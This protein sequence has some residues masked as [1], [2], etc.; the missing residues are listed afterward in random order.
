MPLAT[1][2]H[3]EFSRARPASQTPARGELIGC[4]EL[5]V[6]FSSSERAGNDTHTAAPAIAFAAAGEFEALCGQAGDERSA[7]WHIHFC[8]EGLEVNAHVRRS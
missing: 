5:A 7:A 3:Q 1:L 6:C 2:E 4:E 8:R